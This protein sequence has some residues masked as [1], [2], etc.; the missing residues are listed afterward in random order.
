M[1]YFDTKNNRLVY[2]EQ[3]ASPEFWDTQWNEK[4]LKKNIMAVSDQ[5]FV[6]RKTKQYL[7]APA[8]ILEGGCG[9]GQYVYALNRWGYDTTGLDYA[10]ETVKKVNELFPEMKVILGDVRELPFAEDTFDGY[11][12][13]GVIEH[14]YD[15]FEGIAREMKRVVRPGGF[16]FVTFPAF[17][18]LRRLKARLGQY[19]VFNDVGFEK[20]KF[21]QFALDPKK[22]VFEFEKL[23][24]ITREVYSL[25]G[26]KGLKDEV[27]FLKLVLRPIY[28]S[29]LFIMKILREGINRVFRRFSGHS[30]LCIFEL[31]KHI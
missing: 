7:S 8:K 25:D 5:S 10:P 21:Y 27:K 3:N 13:F 17:S 2:V 24:F 31:R 11:W 16:V 28:D 30:V 29:K 14:F 23:G 19:L 6:K 20:D 22:V 1:K 9:R 4:D 18:P 26:I 12:S 15:G